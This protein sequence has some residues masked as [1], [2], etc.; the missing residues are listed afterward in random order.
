MAN[1]A[2]IV[3]LLKKEH[4][5]LSTEMRGIALGKIPPRYEGETDTIGSCTAEDR[6]GAEGTM[7]EGESGEEDG[8][9]PPRFC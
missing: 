5:R 7:G 9:S 3:R 4:D 2:R 8:L 6:G 1:L